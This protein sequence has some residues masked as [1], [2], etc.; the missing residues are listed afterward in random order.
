MHA[1]WPVG[2]RASVV[3]HLPHSAAVGC[4][5]AARC[6]FAF[7]ACRAAAIPLADAA[8][9]HRYRCLLPPERLRASVPVQG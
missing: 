7:D 3:W 5:F 8:P 1:P 9:G 2:W 6:P 4:G